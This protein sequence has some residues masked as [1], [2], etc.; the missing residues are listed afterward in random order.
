MAARRA[1]AG[2]LAG[3]GGLLLSFA[4]AASAR[5][6]TPKPDRAA[7]PLCAAARV[8]V[9]KTGFTADASGNFRATGTWQAS[10]GATGVFL[11][12]RIDSDR[13]KSEWQQGAA[14]QW[15]Y[16][17]SFPEC[18]G[19]TTRIHAIPLVTVGDHEVIC[20]EQDRSVAAN[21]ESA[22][23]PAAAI[24]GCSWTCQ[25]GP[26]AV[27]SGS[28]TAR[29]SGDPVGFAPYWGLDDGGYAAGQEGSRSG[30]W[31]ERITCAP[32]ERVSFKVRGHG[33]AG[34]WS[35]P[36]EIPCGQSKP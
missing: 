21:F 1:P 11:E 2:A 15:A 12:Y 19:H 30:P 16:A 8:A 29:A 26:P 25:A 24:V 33:G 5:A 13:Y 31:T 14:G 34:G 17:D 20:F 27:C 23:L 6:D 36:V 35:P 4:M 7:A 3:L 9:A 18:G 22:C 28:C 32:G 10:G